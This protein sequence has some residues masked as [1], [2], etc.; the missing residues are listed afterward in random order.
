[1]I[2]TDMHVHSCFSSDSSEQ[3]ES[4]IETAIQ[5]GFSYVYF[6]DHHDQDFPI[7]PSAPDMDFQLDFKNYIT[8]IQQLREQYRSMI[9]V[10][11]GV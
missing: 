11:I 5:K 2:T 4:I 3:M 9:D 6:T 7:H 1:M 10:R 8:K